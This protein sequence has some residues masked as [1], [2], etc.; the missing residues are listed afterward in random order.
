M[1]ILI[2]KRRKGSNRFETEVRL[3]DPPTGEI[4]RCSVYGITKDEA[5]T[6]A[7]TLLMG[8]GHEV[9]EYR[10]SKSVLEPLDAS[11]TSVTRYEGVLDEDS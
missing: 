11:V 7:K 4:K 5:I 9:P 10:E 3:V 2:P 8:N 1:Q 6:K